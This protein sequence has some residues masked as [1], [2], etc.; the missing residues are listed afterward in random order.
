MQIIARLPVAWHQQQQRHH[1]AFKTHHLTYPVSDTHNSDHGLFFKPARIYARMRAIA[2]GASNI[3]QLCLIQQI[4]SSVTTVRSHRWH[5]RRRRHRWRRR[6]CTQARTRA[7]C[8]DTR[9]QSV[10]I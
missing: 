9:T 6:Q 10:V 4:K 5:R 1:L 8:D 2:F 3:E 7:L